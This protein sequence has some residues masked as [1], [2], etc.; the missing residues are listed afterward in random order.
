MSQVGDASSESSKGREEFN[1][2][3]DDDKVFG[4]NGKEKIH[5]DR[6][7]WEEPAKGEKDAI[8]CPRGPNHRNPLI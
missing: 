3:K 8:D 6:P 4:R 1:K 5:V 7:V 2:A